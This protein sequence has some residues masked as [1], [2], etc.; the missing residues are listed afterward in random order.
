MD[1]TLEVSAEVAKTVLQRR[2]HLPDMRVPAVQSAEVGTTDGTNDVRIADQF[3]V[4]VARCIGE[5]NIAELA[6][7]M[8]LLFVASHLLLVGEALEAFGK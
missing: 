2:S 4:V 6:K 1:E 5:V 8:L 7:I 3:V